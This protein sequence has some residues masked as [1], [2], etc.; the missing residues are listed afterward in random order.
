MHLI[1]YI[2]LLE[3]ENKEQIYLANSTTQPLRQREKMTDLSTCSVKGYASRASIYMSKNMV[4]IE[5]K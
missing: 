2:L 5:E 1:S 4:A 3:H